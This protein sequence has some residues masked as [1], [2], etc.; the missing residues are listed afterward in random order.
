MSFLEIL[1]CF[2]LFFVAL[3]TFALRRISQNTR[4]IQ[5]ELIALNGHADRTANCLVRIEGKASRS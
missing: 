2:L 5:D 1:G 3:S 4:E